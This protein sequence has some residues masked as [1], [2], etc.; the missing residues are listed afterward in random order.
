[1]PA[2]ENATAQPVVTET[3]KKSKKAIRQVS[4]KLHSMCLYMLIFFRLLVL[5]SLM[6]L[7]T[8]S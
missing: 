7:L 5:L 2:I 4:T 8:K 6:L 1:M 3:D